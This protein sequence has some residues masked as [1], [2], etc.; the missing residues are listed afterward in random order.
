M[1]FARRQARMAKERPITDKH[2]LWASWLLG[3]A[4]Y[5][6]PGKLRGPLHPDARREYEAGASAAA[7]GYV[8]IPNLNE[9]FEMARHV[10]AGNPPHTYR[11]SQIALA[12]DA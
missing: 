9:A 12:I 4:S 1:T 11:G 10:Q 2:I 3:A 8:K 6:H 5:Y 7:S